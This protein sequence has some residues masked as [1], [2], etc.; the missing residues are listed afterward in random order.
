MSNKLLIVGTVP[1]PIGGVSVHV[2]RLLKYLKY[3][4]CD[5]IFCDYKKINVRIFSH[6]LNSS[7]IHIHANN[8]F[9]I[10]FC[11][12]LSSIF[13]KKIIITIHGEFLYE[14]N[15]LLHNF[16]EKLSVKFSDFP[17]LL[18]K[19]DVDK[20]LILN[21]NALFISSFIT[22]YNEPHLPKNIIDLVS[23]N[24]HKSIF[25][26]NAYRMNF[27]KS[28]NEIY[29]I[30]ELTNYFNISPQFYFILSDPSGE[31]LSYFNSNNIKLN[32]NIL[33][34]NSRHSFY[35]V[36]QISDCFIRNTITDGDSL[37]VRESLYLNKKVIATDCVSRPK[38]VILKKGSIDNAIKAY[39]STQ[40]N[41]FDKMANG[42][43]KILDLYNSI[44]KSS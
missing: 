26:S 25:C 2:S 4:K 10:L 36:L 3:K 39:Q 31:Y 14:R 29:G 42:A 35:R 15:G 19:K 11:I 30:L 13:F 24:K 22:P 34:I 16:F 37:S 28:G 27:D 21:K 18:N 41:I 1:P 43:E 8:P 40:Q 12:I 33:I 9:F 5:H 20:A 7:I 32:N 6:F 44:D 17:I 38:S 23:K